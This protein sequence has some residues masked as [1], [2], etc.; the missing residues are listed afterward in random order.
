MISPGDTGNLVVQEEALKKTPLLAVVASLVVVATVLAAETFIVK[1]KAT[2]LR[3]SP[4]FYASAVVALKAGDGVEKVGGTGDWIQV[5]TA[6]G[7]TGWIHISALQPKKFNLSALTGGVQTQAS[8]NEVAL[9]SKGFNKQVEDSYR[10][11]HKSVSFVWVDKMLKIAVPAGQED[12]FLKDG[13]LGD[14][15]GGK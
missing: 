5:K 9:A 15:R 4:K 6:S 1:V 8:A 7:A 10:A 11:K 14:Y 3:S 13:R 2:S 12:S